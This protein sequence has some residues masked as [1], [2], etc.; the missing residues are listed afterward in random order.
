MLYT[1]KNHLSAQLLSIAAI[2]LSP[3]A[4]DAST[5]GDI[6][7]AQ[8]LNTSTLWGDSQSYHSCNVVNVST[9]TINV[10]VELIS[11]AGSV[12]TSG[13]FTLTAGNG[14]E[15]NF[16]GGGFT[17]FARCRF[18][19]NY[20][21]VIRANLSTFHTPDSGTTYQTYALSEAR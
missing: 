20:P 17:G 3:A 19:T 8:V 16:S 10:T 1:K 12:L 6:S 4:A 7:V 14:Y 11:Y 18:T 13:T 2:V 5:A 9:A 21:S 15:L